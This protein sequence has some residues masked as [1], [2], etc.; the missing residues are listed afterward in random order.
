MITGVMTAFR[1]TIIRLAV[2]G[3]EGQEQK[4]EAVIDK[5]FDGTCT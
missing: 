3:P 1:Q 4:V 2:R 5:G